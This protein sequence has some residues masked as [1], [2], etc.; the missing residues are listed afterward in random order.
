MPITFHVF[1]NI[2]LVPCF[3]LRSKHLFNFD[4]RIECYLPEL[5]APLNDRP[6]IVSNPIYV[7]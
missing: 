4:Y 2:T 1:F 6:W 7:R 3:F 5:P